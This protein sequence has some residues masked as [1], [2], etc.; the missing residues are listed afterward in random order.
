MPQ[1][2]EQTNPSHPR[3]RSTS[4]ALPL[5]PRPTIAGSPRPDMQRTS[6]TA[7]HATTAP[8]P[9][10][11]AV[12]NALS[13]EQEVKPLPPIADTTSPAPTP[14]L[15]LVH[16]HC[17]QTYHYLTCGHGTFQPTTA[18]SAINCLSPQPYQMSSPL[19]CPDCAYAP[20]RIGTEADPRCATAE[21]FENGVR[22]HGVLET[23]VR[24]VMDANHANRESWEGCTEE[25]RVVVNRE[26]VGEMVGGPVEL[27]GGLVGLVV[28][29]EDS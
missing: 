19:Y 23:I 10:S 22:I 16:I 6:S 15:T 18:C 7:G 21:A 3:S 27:V 26:G 1:H 12:G 25:E 28:R 9:S 5:A 2:D 8:R 24:E 11:L 4:L 17:H 13:S 20:H 14:I 29:R